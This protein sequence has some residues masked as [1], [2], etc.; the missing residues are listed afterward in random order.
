M[1]AREPLAVI[2]Q[3]VQDA[4]VLLAHL[5]CA[6]HVSA[7]TEGAGIRDVPIANDRRLQC[8][9]FG[10]VRIDT[11]DPPADA[12][13]MAVL[14]DQQPV[15]A[16][17]TIRKWIGKEIQSRTLRQPPDVLER[18]QFANVCERTI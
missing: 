18:R 13:G 10:G 8:G 12:P 6:I 1:V 4:A 9:G 17:M 15:A 5:R 14:F 7:V 16:L 3:S 11:R 2:A